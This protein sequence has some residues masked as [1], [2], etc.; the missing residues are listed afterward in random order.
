MKLRYNLIFGNIAIAL[1]FFFILLLSPNSSSGSTIQSAAV[2]K[3]A[4]N[5]LD[6]VSSSQIAQTVSTV[7]HLPETTAVKNQNEDVI[8]EFA[9]S[10]AVSNVTAK[11]M[12]V[13]TSFVSKNDIETYI[14]KPGED[15]ASIASKFNITSNSIL[16]SNNITG[17]SVAVGTKLLIPPIT[18]IVYTVKSGDTLSSLSTKY[19]AN[20]QQLTAYNDA[21]ISGIK[22]GEQILIP[23]GQPPVAPVYNFFSPTFASGASNGYD[24]GYCTWYVATQISLPSN[25]GNAS[26][27]AYY[28]GL[29][30][31]NVSSTPTVGAIAQTP[32]AAGGLGHVAVVIGVSGDQV[33]IRDMNNYGDGG[34]WDRVGSGWVSVRTFPN[35]ISK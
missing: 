9:K 20:L 11:P 25:W 18:G 16:W 14:V 7:S 32:Y 13:S 30:G 29:S 1:V 27:W 24:F 19:G 5:P 12:I 26:S 34:G 2:S 31:W 4:I 23:N 22:V 33:Q 17:N 10:A 28:A 21:E 8:A 3:N 15:I 6:Q 35:Y